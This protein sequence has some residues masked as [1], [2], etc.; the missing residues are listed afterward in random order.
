VVVLGLVSSRKAQLPAF[1]R[2]RLSASIGRY[3]RTSLPEHD[4]RAAGYRM[5]SAVFQLEQVGCHAIG[6]ITRQRQL[7]WRCAGRSTGATTTR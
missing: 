1:I 3:G 2:L 5:D 7:G 4:V 6:V